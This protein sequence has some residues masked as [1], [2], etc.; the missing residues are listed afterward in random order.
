M[1]E[2]DTLIVHDNS[3][4][5]FMIAQELT[6]DDITAIV[7]KIAMASSIQEAVHLLTSGV[8]PKTVIAHKGIENGSTVAELIHTMRSIE[9][10]DLIRLGIVSGEFF[11]E[12]VCTT[13]LEL[14]ADFGWDIS[15]NISHPVP[16]WVTAITNLGYLHP[17]ELA[18]RGREIVLSA[19]TAQK[20]LELLGATS[21]PGR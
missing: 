1:R 15:Q 7:E 20:R 5:N 4:L 3:T 12:Q 14:G 8:H 10:G 19:Q 11:G 9:G 18:L 2:I 6:G 21:A 17:Q 13:A 16:E